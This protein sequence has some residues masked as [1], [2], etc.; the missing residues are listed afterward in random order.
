[1]Y[2]KDVICFGLFSFEMQFVPLCIGYK[3][4]TKF[5]YLP[6]IPYRGQKQNWLKIQE[7]SHPLTLK[8]SKGLQKF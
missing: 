3:P 6:L 4:V 1:M 5:V 2:F 7:F 8:S